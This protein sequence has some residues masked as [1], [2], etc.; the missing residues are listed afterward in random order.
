MYKV[1]ECNVVSHPLLVCMDMCCC[2]VE[3]LH[4][5][6]DCFRM[7]VN[8]C[9]IRRFFARI[10]DNCKLYGTHSGVL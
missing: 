8:V 7:P 2:M 10:L 4:M 1:C 6:G 9:E 5:K 3:V